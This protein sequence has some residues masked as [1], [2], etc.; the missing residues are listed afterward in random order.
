[1]DPGEVLS[2]VPTVGVLWA[3]IATKTSLS[4]RPE[5]KGYDLKNNIKAPS[6]NA[7]IK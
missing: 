6:G 2:K 5:I 7:E 3:Q 4:V 1:M